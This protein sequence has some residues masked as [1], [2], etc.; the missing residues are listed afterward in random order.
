MAQPVATLRSAASAGCAFIATPPVRLAT[1]SKYDQ[2]IASKSVIDGD[3]FSV[4]RAA[5]SP[6]SA[7]IAALRGEHDANCAAEALLRW[8]R[9]GALT[10]MA[11]EDANLSR[12]RM[13]IDILS[14]ASRLKRQGRD[15]SQSPEARQWFATLATQTMRFYDLQAGP[16]SRRNNHRYWAGLSVGASGYF[17][18]DGRM[19]GWAKQSFETG[20]CQIAADGTLPLELARGD[21]ALEYHLYA[22]RAL[23]GLRD[24]AASHGDRLAGPCATRLTALEDLL[25]EPDRAA[26]IVEARN[27]IGQS[28]PRRWNM[29]A[30]TG[31]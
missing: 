9:A 18:G 1:T 23:N 13:V 6:V 15:L 5:L 26:A 27:G 28:M 24:L 3:A 2:S 17:L 16:V 11:T 14:I 19:V 21:K 29:A 31:F 4:R 30:A 7:A 10:D 25:A 12:D 22:Y 20:A 8:A